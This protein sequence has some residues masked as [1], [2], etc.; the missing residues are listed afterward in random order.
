MIAMEKFET[1]I[2]S[3]SPRSDTTGRAT[4]SATPI[5]MSG[6]RAVTIDRY[7]ITGS[8]VMSST[9]TAV[10]ISSDRSMELNRSARV[11]DGPVK[12]T[13]GPAAGDLVQ[14]PADG[15]G[16]VV[17]PR[18]ADVTLGRDGEVH[19]L[20]AGLRA[21]DCAALLAH[22]EDIGN[23]LVVRGESLHY[24][25][26]PVVVGRVDPTGVGHHHAAERRGGG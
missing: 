11:G 4:P 3:C 23:V 9:D 14:R 13:G 17:G 21:A 25:A 22:V 7:A 12:C 8:I 5:V 19:G 18:A 16:A 20:R 6:T 26:I 24:R 2:R 15:D 1:P 10:M